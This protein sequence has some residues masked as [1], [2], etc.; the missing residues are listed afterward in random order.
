MS[1]THTNPYQ[2]R[3]HII[4]RWQKRECCA[5]SFQFRR[6]A[7]A[8]Q[9]RSHQVGYYVLPFIATIFVLAFSVFGSASDLPSSPAATLTA[10]FL[11]TFFSVMLSYIECNQEAK[12]ELTH[13]PMRLPDHQQLL[14]LSWFLAAGLRWW[15][16]SSP[17]VLSFH[18]VFPTRIGSLTLN[19]FLLLLV[20]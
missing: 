20:T 10:W 3:E 17:R 6:K 9:R 13:L 15:M 5:A 14:M 1:L 7:L 11:C 12:Y 8:S 2:R 19:C 18:A 16:H 4:C